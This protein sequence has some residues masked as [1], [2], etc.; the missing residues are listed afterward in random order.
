MRLKGRM[1]R[2]GVAIASD[3]A[4]APGRYH[5]LAS[6]A[7]LSVLSA[8]GAVRLEEGSLEGGLAFPLTIASEGQEPAPAT[9]LFS[10][11]ARLRE[12]T[13]RFDD[14]PPGLAPDRWTAA[15]VSDSAGHFGAGWLHWDR[16]GA[17]LQVA[18]ARAYPL[19]PP[20]VIRFDA[21]G[22][23]VEIAHNG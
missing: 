12:Q 21:D 17:V 10:D 1:V 4:I 19:A 13:L 8:S 6:G 9:E 16:A 22:E 20:F 15:S 18:S 11:D 3:G 5:G 7:V 2:A 23:A 14:P